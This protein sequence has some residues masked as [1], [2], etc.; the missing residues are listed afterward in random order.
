MIF[1]SHNHK[2]KPIVEPIAMRLAEVYGQ[3]N[4]FYDSWS[5]Q[6]GEGIID[7]M[8]EGL[9]RC[10]YFFYFVSANSLTSSMVKLEWQNALVR[11]AQNMIKFIPVRLDQSLLPPIMLQTLYIDLFSNGIDVAI[12]Q[13]VDVINGTNTF[14]PET[15]SFSN[16]I[17]YKYRE[18]NKLIVEC[19]ALHYLEP[20]T[21][22]S[23]MTF[24]DVDKISY[25][26]P[27]EVAYSSGKHKEV[28]VNL[29]TK[30]NFITIG[31]GRGTLPG[32]PLVVEF[33]SNELASFEII[34]VLHQ[35]SR[36]NFAPILVVNGR[37][38]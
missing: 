14:R 5:I 28:Q 7:R 38:K 10:K 19:R 15:T 32:F 34:A 2:D 30:A 31:L 23:F 4:V 26:V 33:T 18:E 35:V 17:A 11:A 16:L 36:E 3:E 22:F 9:S 21:S 25:S 6:P 29:R 1:I 20:I 24:D 12:R 13:M 27:G 8:N 37:P